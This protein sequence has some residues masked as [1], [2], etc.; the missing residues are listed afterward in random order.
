MTM[1]HANSASFAKFVA[2]LLLELVDLS[3]QVLRRDHGP[4]SL[5]NALAQLRSFFAQR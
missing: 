2:M 4:R 5:R 3:G 1:V